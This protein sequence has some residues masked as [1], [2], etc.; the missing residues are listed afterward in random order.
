[1][2]PVEEQLSK[3]QDEWRANV[4]NHMQSQEA[5]M[6]KLLSKVTEIQAEYVRFSHLESA[7]KR[8]TSLENDR[9]KVVGAMVLLNLLGGVILYLIGK[10]WK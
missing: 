6:D 1:M 7:C 9:Q 10:F 5:K 8:I 4:M 2:T 3:L